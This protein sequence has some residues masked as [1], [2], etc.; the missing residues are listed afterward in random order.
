MLMLFTL[1]SCSENLDVKQVNE[2]ERY[3]SASLKA[4]QHPLTKS[5]SFL[6]FSLGS[7]VDEASA[8]LQEL[9]RNGKLFIPSEYGEYPSVANHDLK[10]VYV[11][12]LRDGGHIQLNVSFFC[13]GGRLRSILGNFICYSDP[14]LE[15]ELMTMYEEKLGKSRVFNDADETT[16]YYWLDGGQKT[17]LT[18][19]HEK[20]PPSEQPIV[21]YSALSITTKQQQED[22]IK[23]LQDS[24]E[25]AKLRTQTIEDL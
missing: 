20:N 1:F 4:E 16:C 23:R 2:K 7:T 11:F 17:L 24:V 9:K 21:E 13:T 19:P 3:L 12:Y 10:A 5:Q 15:K 14:A 6:G 8:H 25:N 18:I 22:D